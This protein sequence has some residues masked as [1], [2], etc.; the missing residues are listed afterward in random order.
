MSPTPFSRVGKASAARRLAPLLTTIAVFWCSNAAAQTYCAV[1]SQIDNNQEACF[2]T[3]GAAEEY[4]FR[5]VLPNERRRFLKE[6][7]TSAE[8]PN[9]SFNV[10]TG[11]QNV[12]VKYRTEPHPPETEIVTWYEARRPSGYYNWADEPYPDGFITQLPDENEYGRATESELQQDMLQRDD[13]DGPGEFDGSYSSNPHGE[14]VNK[15][16]PMSLGRKQMRYN[17]ETP[18]VGRGFDSGSHSWNVFGRSR[19]WCPRGMD[20]YAS[21][22]GK[23]MC[24]NSETG[25]LTIKE[26]PYKS[27]ST[28]KPCV[29]ATGAKE[30]H[31]QDFSWGR[32]NFTRHYT[33]LAG[34]PY[35]AVVGNHWTHDFQSMIVPLRTGSSPARRYGIDER[36]NLEVYVEIDANTLRSQNET[37]RRLVRTGI[38]ATPFK[39]YLTEREETFDAAGKLVAI[40]LPDSPADSVDLVYCDIASHLAGLCNAPD[41]L[42]KVTDRR[43]RTLEFLYSARVVVGEDPATSHV[44]PP[45]LKEI[46]TANTGLVQYTHDAS[47]RLLSAVYPDGSERIYH[48]QELP[49]LCVS[50]TGQPLAPCEPTQMANLLTGV[51]DERGV[52]LSNY[53]YDNLERVTSSE[54]AGGAYPEKLEYPNASTRVVTHPTG[55]VETTT[56]NSYFTHR[57]EI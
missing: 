38:P 6:Q 49:N 19:W 41:E 10:N 23:S 12:V 26:L 15:L 22:L 2:N 46:R 32:W 4:L 37:G 13:E 27:C 28:S 54:W 42:W 31:E 47:G 11:W 45:R 30:M 7:E 29:P 14:L 16:D 34:L 25:T 17:L 35:D 39:L 1:N 56:L 9:F 44:E 20:S 51:T 43:G 33:S 36:R 8:A 24:T 18:Q 55:R 21:W 5:E 57:S 3:R 40:E 50:S 52:R 53:T 48:Y